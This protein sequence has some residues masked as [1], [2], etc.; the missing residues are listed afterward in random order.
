M[1]NPFD[2]MLKILIIGD[3]N[4][5]KTSLLLKYTENTL[6]NPS[7]PTLG[8]DFKFSTILLDYKI[9]T[10]QI[11]DTAGQDRFRNLAS[12]YYRGAKGMFI[13]FDVANR[14]SFNNVAKWYEESLMHLTENI[15]R[16]L[17]GNKCDIKE[18]DRIV[19]YEEA[20]CLASTF[21]MEYIETSAVNGDNIEII[22]LKIAKAI[23][24]KPVKIAR[25]ISLRKNPNKDKK[26]SR[27]RR[28]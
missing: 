20:A 12:S 24:T 21:G 11:W 8:V 13:V 25:T 7:S 28:C 1:N 2:I 17:I 23:I 18:P 14:L 26:P 4:T 6:T 3:G 10:L 16:F 9:I 15:V 22:F 5:G 27:C 19:S